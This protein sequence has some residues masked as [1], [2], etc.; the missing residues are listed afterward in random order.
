MLRVMELI[1]LYGCRFLLQDKYTNKLTNIYSQAFVAIATSSGEI[2]TLI[3]RNSNQ[4]DTKL[5]L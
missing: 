3:D 5:Q 4:V 1:L 2:Q